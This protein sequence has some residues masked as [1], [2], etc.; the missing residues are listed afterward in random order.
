MDITDNLFLEKIVFNTHLFSLEFLK[1]LSPHLGGLTLPWKKH[2]KK[3]SP[4]DALFQIGWNWPIGSEDD[5]GNVESLRHR[6]KCQH[7]LPPKSL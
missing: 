4:A 7:I 2:F 1:I 5:A 3:P 6:L